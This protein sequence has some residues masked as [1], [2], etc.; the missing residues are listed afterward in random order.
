MG[1]SAWS[2]DCRSPRRLSSQ[3]S[4]PERPSLYCWPAP[5]LVVAQSGSPSLVC[6]TMLH[7]EAPEAAAKVRAVAVVAKIKVLRN[8]VA[9]LSGCQ[10]SHIGGMRTLLQRSLRRSDV[11]HF[12]CESPVTKKAILA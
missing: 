4:R 2:R 8:M 12:I 9:V 10:L 7:A 11:H 3:R 6:P 5:S 1:L